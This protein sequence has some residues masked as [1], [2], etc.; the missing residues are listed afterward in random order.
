MIGREC[1]SEYIVLYLVTKRNTILYKLMQIAITSILVECSWLFSPTPP[2]GML[3]P[4]DLSIAGYPGE[5]LSDIPLDYNE[6]PAPQGN[7]FTP[8]PDTAPYHPQD[9]PQ[10]YSVPVLSED[11]LPPPSAPQWLTV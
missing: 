4:G 10:V 11:Y 8:S 1:L 3:R 6:Q 9:Q 5:A 7:E 2:L